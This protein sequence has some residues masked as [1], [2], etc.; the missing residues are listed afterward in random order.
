[1]PSVYKSFWKELDTLDSTRH[2]SVS[3]SSTTLTLNYSRGLMSPIDVSCEC[4]ECARA[5]IDSA[6]NTEAGITG[7]YDTKV[8]QYGSHSWCLEGTQR[9]LFF[10]ETRAH[11]SH[12]RSTFLKAHVF[13]ACAQIWSCDD[14]RDDTF[15]THAALAAVGGSH[16]GLLFCCWSRLDVDIDASALKEFH[17]KLPFFAEK[18]SL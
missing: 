13:W 7:M 15:Q 17:M 1:M 5:S 6:D 9:A 18:E 16:V 8:T 14:A 10:Y 3:S 11:F 4:A 12:R 2:I